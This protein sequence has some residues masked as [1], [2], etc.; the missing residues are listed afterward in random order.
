MSVIDPAVLD[1]LSSIPPE[2]WILLT[3]GALVLFFLGRFSKRQPPTTS[4]QSEGEGSEELLWRHEKLVLWERH[5]T[6]RLARQVNLQESLEALSK[7]KD[8]RIRTSLSFLAE[9]AREV[10]QRIGTDLSRLDLVKTR[11]ESLLD[12]EKERPE[13]IRACIEMAE[14]QC[15]RLSEVRDQMRPVSQS[16]I[17]AEEA[18][19][20]SVGDQTLVREKLLEAKGY[21]KE[22]SPEWQVLTEETDRRIRETL[23]AGD[24]PGF[25]AITE[26]LLVDGGVTDSLVRGNESGL[27]GRLDDLIELLEDAEEAEDGSIEEPELLPSSG[28]APPAPGSEKS[29]NG[30]HGLEVGRHERPDPVE[31]PESGSWIVFRSNDVNLWGQDVY[32]G[33]NERARKMEMIPSWA[34]W[35]SIRRADTGETVY[36]RA[37][38]IILSSAEAHGPIGFNGSHELFYEARHLGMYSESC[39]N[40]VETRFTYGGWGFGHRVGDLEDTEESTQA[41]GWAGKEISGDTVFEIALHT[42]L[43]E[44]GEED[45]LLEPAGVSTLSSS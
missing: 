6:E 29:I 35:V 44:L 2:A 45:L 17:A 20:P 41:S 18:F 19:D 9:E 26:I 5:E 42:E 40:E 38:D 21:L 34:N 43:P 33:A 4:G 7:P 32:R 28:F 27:S 8:L 36:L 12:G 13:A 15:S 23:E 37:D 10:R 22:T 24:R 31:A 3:F 14:S 1:R 16:L 30:H 39:P 11:L 25:R